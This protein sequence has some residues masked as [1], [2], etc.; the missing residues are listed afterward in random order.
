MIILKDESY[1]IFKIEEFQTGDAAFRER[2]IVP[3]HVNLSEI[4]HIIPLLTVFPH[5]LCL[6]LVSYFTIPSRLSIWATFF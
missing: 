4:P 6:F 3:S 5:L 1:R 2:T